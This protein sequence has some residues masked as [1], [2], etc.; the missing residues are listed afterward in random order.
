MINI[1]L[2]FRAFDPHEL[3]CHFVA[4]HAGLYRREE[5]QV[6]LMDI[7]FMADDALAPGI[8]Q[9]SCG[10][11][12][13]SAL[14][15]SPQRIVFVAADRP[16]FWLYG[17]HDLNRIEELAGARIATF[18]A[19][20]PP[21]QLANMILDKHGISSEDGVS[22]MP[23]RDD[24]ARLGLLNSGDVDAAVISSS[25]SPE[26]IRQMGFNRLCFF[27]DE[28]RIPTT[29]LAVHDSFLVR[30]P[31]SVQA[32]VNALKDSLPVIQKNPEVTAEVLN[33]YFDL[34]NN[35]AVQTA[36]LYSR[37]FTDHGRTTPEIAQGAINALC[38]SL[39]ISPVPDWEKIYRF[40]FLC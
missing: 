8:C 6:E 10:A 34:E 11:A 2:G 24:V 37:C 25:M 16:M 3:L 14:K 4:L 38:K 23:A 30:E 27:G 35:L 33:R 12:L 36:G 29:G 26:K 21:H 39:S 20:A 1:Q 9:A 32:M 18:P 17:R 13:S 31:D 5:I 40:S 22:L 19:A 15:G 7:T 28:I